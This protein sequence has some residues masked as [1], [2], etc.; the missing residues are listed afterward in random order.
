MGVCGLIWLQHSRIQHEPEGDGLSSRAIIWDM[1]GV[2]ADS[3]DAH[4]CAWQ[5]LYREL[6]GTITRQQFAETF[7]MSN[8]P[9]LRQ[10]LGENT[11]EDELKALGLRKEVFFRQFVAEHVHILPGVRAWM[12]WAKERGYSQAIAS[13]GEMANI[14]AVVHAL[15]VANYLDALVSGAF[16]PRSK[17]DPAIFLQ[18][19]AA[20][21]VN[22]HNCLVIED[23]IV[24][25]EAAKRAG[26]FCLAV[27]TTHPPERLADADHVVD[28]LEELNAEAFDAL[29]R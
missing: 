4:Y 6:G 10:W 8:L 13:S 29:W 16:L 22:A 12:E 19:A 21:G 26:M 7:G 24:G 3:G 2:V 1:D 14:V 15:D 27:T 28:S 5:A 18:A 25:V 17:P 20:L 23:G 11:P 9:I